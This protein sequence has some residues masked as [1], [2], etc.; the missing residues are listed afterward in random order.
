M[1]KL[2]KM[3]V[4]ALLALSLIL[5]CA[6]AEEAA[7][8]ETP[9]PVE[10]AE[11]LE[12]EIIPEVVATEEADDFGSIPNKYKLDL[13]EVTKTNNTSGKGTVVRTEGDDYMGGLYARVTWVYTLSNDDSFAYCAMKEVILNGK[14]TLTFNMV[15]PKAPY[16]A[17]LD[18]VQVALVTD[19]EAD[20]KGAYTALA[21]AR[22]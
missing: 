1:N 18:A 16:G 9:E 22:K 3:L 21:S 2:L 17:T 13:S 11:G 10:E 19:P 12:V 4:A 15:S 7:E 20:A 14:D 6:L 8:I 5:C